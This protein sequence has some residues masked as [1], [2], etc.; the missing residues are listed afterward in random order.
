MEEGG[1][2]MEVTAD[3]TVAEEA[4]NAPGTPQ[5]APVATPVEAVQMEVEA[6]SNNA[7][8]EEGS[9]RE[10]SLRARRSRRG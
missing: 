3:T 8:T 10:P 5:G 7:G 9:H 6:E 4:R 1:A 2:A